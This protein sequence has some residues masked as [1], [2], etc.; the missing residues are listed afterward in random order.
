VALAD[1]V[2]SPVSLGLVTDL[3]HPVVARE[4][5]LCG[6]LIAVCWL[7]TGHV[8]FVPDRTV[9]FLECLTPWVTARGFAHLIQLGGLFA[10]GGLLVSRFFRVS[11]LTLAL[12]I[13]AT[14]V[15]S[16]ATFA[17]NRVFCA[18]LLLML[19]L[20]DRGRARRLPRL[21][22]AIVYLGAAADKVLNADWRSGQFLQS[23]AE[24]LARY[25]QLWSPGWQVGEPNLAAQAFVE[26]ANRLPPLALALSLSWAVITLELALAW[27]FACRRGWSVGATVLFHAAIFG[28]T[29][30]S[31]GMFF[32][33]GLAAVWTVVELPAHD[34]TSLA[35]PGLWLLV[36]TLLASP[37]VRVW[38][39]WPLLLVPVA[40]LLG[41]RQAPYVT[42]EG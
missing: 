39:I 2:R 35:S 33:A 1:T 8:G 4:H 24:E 38:M 25:G 19:A 15:A 16:Q 36:A 40:W 23:F 18:A 5:V 17:N 9:P 12:T 26:V 11:A 22:V 37:L 41:A 6:K 30:S 13:A 27:G 7:V 34:R 3:D 28:L 20:S 42:N 14:T 21:Q 32:Y 29:G 10:C 31:F